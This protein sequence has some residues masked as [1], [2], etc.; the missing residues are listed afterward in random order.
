MMNDYLYEGLG[1]EYPPWGLMEPNSYLLKV[2]Q[3]SKATTENFELLG[4][5]AR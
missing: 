4:R 2:T 1:S 3:G 5:R